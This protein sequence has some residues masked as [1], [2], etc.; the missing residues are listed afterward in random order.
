MIK[1]VI[2][3]VLWSSFVIECQA[4]GPSLRP[5]E[6]SEEFAAILDTIAPKPEEDPVEDFSPGSAASRCQ[7]GQATLRLVDGRAPV[8]PWLKQRFG[9]PCVRLQ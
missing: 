6:L 9:G 4:Q 3:F 5:L 7:T 2:C 8:V 1:I